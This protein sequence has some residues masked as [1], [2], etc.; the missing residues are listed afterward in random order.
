MAEKTRCEICNRTFKDGE[1]LA[2]HNRD[3]HGVNLNEKVVKSNFNN[4]KIRNWSVFIL[5]FIALIGGVYFMISNI[6]TLPPTDID[7]H[8]EKNPKSHVLR[9]PMPI[10]VQK[11]MLEHVD[12]IEGGIPGVIINYNCKDY[13]CEPDLIENL[14]KFAVDY[15]Y[16]YVAPY[17]RINTKIALTKLNKIEILKEYDDVKI[18]S[19]IERR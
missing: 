10:A 12:G 8:I 16:V 2:M 1:G 14:E 9:E 19:F 11:H 17:K 18:K 15:N 4:K 6:E 3:K 7:G 5:V 13:E